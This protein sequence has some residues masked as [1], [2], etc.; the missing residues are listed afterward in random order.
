[1][2]RM[3]I[4]YYRTRYLNTFLKDKENYMI[5]NVEEISGWSTARKKRLFSEESRRGLT[6]GFRVRNV[7]FSIKTK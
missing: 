2:N 1:M 5:D 4:E 6:R 7:F 3:V